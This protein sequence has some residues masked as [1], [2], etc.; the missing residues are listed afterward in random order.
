MKILSWF[1]DL[2]VV[3]NVF[4]L[5]NTNALFYLFSHN[6]SSMWPRAVY[7]SPIKVPPVNFG[8]SKAI[9]G[10]YECWSCEEVVLDINAVRNS[11]TTV[12]SNSKQD[13]TLSSFPAL[14]G[15]FFSQSKNPSVDK[16]FSQ[17]QPGHIKICTSVH[18][19]CNTVL[20]TLLHVLPQFQREMSTKWH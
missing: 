12:W 15:I 5:W 3:P 7:K 9:I 4:L 16:Y 11:H 14:L 18:F 19:L 17:S 6:K 8:G 13:D 20:R 2:H 1:T 10:L